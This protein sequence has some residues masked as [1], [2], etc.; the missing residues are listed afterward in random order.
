MVEMTPEL[1]LLFGLVVLALV[2]LIF[3]LLRPDFVAWGMAVALVVTGLISPSEGF[4][5]FSSP[6]TVTVLSMFVL[7]AAMVRT[8]VVDL[9]A[10]L[11]KRLGGAQEAGLV[12]ALML[13]AGSLSAFMNNVGTT[14]ILLPAVLTAAREAHIPPT[15]LL[16][17][18][19]FGSLLGGLTTLIGTP[20]NLLASQALEQA[21][22]RPFGVFDFF[23]TGGPILL[24]GACYMVILG[25]HL[26]PAR[27]TEMGRKFGL[28]GYV[29]EVVVPMGSPI[30]GKTLAEAELPRRYGLRVLRIR[31]KAEGEAQEERFEWPTPSTTLLVG[32]RLLVQGEVSGLVEDRPGAPFRLWASAKF[33]ADSL[34]G[35]EVE[36]AE[37]ALA[38]GSRL[39]GRSVNESQIRQRFGVL[40]LALRRRGIDR[41][42]RPSRRCL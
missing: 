24:L 22:Y 1:V 11:L 9:L 39:L 17:P 3:E 18:L 23:P 14:A 33:E 15:R 35:G 28:D 10:S 29:T 16:L 40:V 12:A 19:S 7:S 32:D 21:G 8:G 5:G 13:L 6:A 31:R 41:C 2:L 20:A 34:L 42:V 27:E 30:A 25:R 38:P 36:V 37:V 26:I 4:S